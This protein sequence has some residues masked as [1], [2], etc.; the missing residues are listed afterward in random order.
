LATGA[1]AATAT[2][3]SIASSI[4]AWL[5]MRVME[6]AAF[7]MTRRML[8][9]VKER[10]ERLQARGSAGPTAGRRPAA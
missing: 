1:A 7:L 4:G 5:F 6:P 9:G 3:G 10:A 8:L 2:T